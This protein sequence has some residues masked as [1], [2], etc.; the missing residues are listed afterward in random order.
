MN[1]DWVSMSVPDTPTP[2]QR[3]RCDAVAASAGDRGNGGAGVPCIA[4]TTSTLQNTLHQHYVIDYITIV[5]VPSETSSPSLSFLYKN[6]KF[7]TNN[8]GE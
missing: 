2:R 6:L 7:C 1:S 8:F 4:V 3:C 5:T